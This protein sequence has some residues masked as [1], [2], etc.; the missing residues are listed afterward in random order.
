VQNNNV[1]KDDPF[2]LEVESRPLPTPEQPSVNGAQH[3]CTQTCY[4]NCGRHVGT[5]CMAMQGETGDAEGYEKEEESGCV[6]R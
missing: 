6:F 2:W 3:S 4:N 1:P 5:L